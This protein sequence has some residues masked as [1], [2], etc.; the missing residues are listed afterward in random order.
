M[1]FVLFSVQSLTMYLE[2]MEDEVY[3]LKWCFKIKHSL[4]LKSYAM[5]STRLRKNIG[6]SQF[7][8]KREDDGIEMFC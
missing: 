5:F 8:S 2:K 6:L 7:M 4:P 3:W 1:L